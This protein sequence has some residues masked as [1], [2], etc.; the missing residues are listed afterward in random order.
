MTVKIGT[1][2]MLLI[3]V[4]IAHLGIAVWMERNRAQAA[5]LMRAAANRMDPYP[6]LKVASTC[7][8]Q[9]QTGANNTEGSWEDLAQARA[10]DFN[11][12]TIVIQP[13]AIAP[14]APLR[15]VASFGTTAATRFEGRQDY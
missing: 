10:T 4:V 12:E 6:S 2:A 15:I 8:L 13:G 7:R 11:S 1:G 3:L 5:E 9:G 14:G